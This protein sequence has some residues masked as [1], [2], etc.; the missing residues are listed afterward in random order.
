VVAQAVSLLCAPLLT[1]LYLPEEIGALAALTAVVAVLGVLSTGQY[2]QAIMLP[3]DE[4]EAFDV[5]RV[6][7]LAVGGC[8]AVVVLLVGVGREAVAV[9]IGLPPGGQNWIMLLPLL[10]GL[11]GIENIL[12][13]LHVR[14]QQFRPLASAQVLQ[15]AGASAGKIGFG[16]AGYG[17]PGLLLGTTLGHAARLGKLA[18]A[19]L[20]RL[21]AHCEPVPMQTL[22]VLA[23]RYKKFPLLASGASVIQ[24]LA[25]QL[26]IILF[27]A[28]FAPAVVG[29][30]ALAYTMLHMPI[31]LVGLNVNH[32]FQERAARVRTEK[33]ELA[34]L[35]GGV[36]LRLLGL[37]ALLLP[38]VTFYGD[39][40]FPLVFGP[41]WVD[42]GRYAQWISVWLLFVFAAIPVRSIYLVLEHQTEGL[43]WN[44]GIVVV[45]AGTIL[46]G[47]AGGLEPVWVIAVSA[48]TGAVLNWLFALRMLR[49]A[50]AKVLAMIGGSMA[51]CG[52]CLLGHAVLYWVLAVWRSG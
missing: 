47:Y 30:F 23:R 27:T 40:I 31:A 49:M 14:A 43:L 4:R 33:R 6:G 41:E 5:A 44:V 52:V 28:L 32:V 46:T 48:L 11:L 26:P 9:W 7:V 36:Y 21:K 12:V 34:R 24:A 15:Q 39:W 51:V 2:E 17:I 42:A 25:A 38:V 13:R 16:F 1:R 45:L 8:T 10:A 3:D 29:Q 18:Y 35:A 20:P 22:W 50:G 37:G 19:L